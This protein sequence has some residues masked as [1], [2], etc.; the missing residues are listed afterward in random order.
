MDQEWIAALRYL[1][2]KMYRCRLIALD[3]KSH[4]PFHAHAYGTANAAQ[5]EPFIEQALDQRP[6]LARDP[7]LLKPILNTTKLQ[8]AG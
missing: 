4:Q 2:V 7:V 3:Q 5:R 8:V 6:V 1:N